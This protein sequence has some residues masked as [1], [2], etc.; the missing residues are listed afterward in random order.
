MFVSSFVVYYKF[1]LEGVKK[2]TKKDKPCRYYNKHTDTH[3]DTHTEA[4]KKFS[5]CFE[6]NNQ[7]GPNYL[8]LTFILQKRQGI[9]W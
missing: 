8:L 3:T 1:W 4:E 6:L 7:Q 2:K 5:I 9:I